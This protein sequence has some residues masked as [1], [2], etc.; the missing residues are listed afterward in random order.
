LE[1]YWKELRLTPNTIFLAAMIAKEYLDRVQSSKGKIKVF[2]QME[3]FHVCIMIA[4][5]MREN[6]LNCPTLSYLKKM[7][8]IANLLI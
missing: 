5:K 2:D 1:N 7:G 8:G 6:Y 4:S 3:T